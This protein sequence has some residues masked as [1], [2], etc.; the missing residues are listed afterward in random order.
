MPRNLA[1]AHPEHV[2]QVIT[3]ACHIQ[4]TLDDR[5]TLSFLF[6]RIRHRFDPEFQCTS[7]H[8]RGPLPVPSTSI[9]SRSD[10]VAHWSMCL[11][12][13]DDEHENVE[14]YSTHGG[15]GFN[16]F[17]YA[18]VAD[19][20]A[21]SEGEWRPFRAPTWLRSAYPRPADWR[22]HTDTAPRARPT[23]RPRRSGDAPRSPFASREGGQTSSVRRQ[24]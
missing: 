11:D 8:E 17:V 5:N 3:M 7:E 4:S 21:Q 18:V 15:Q 23:G 19:R 20:L 9:Y 1:R 16:P 22:D 2:R 6:D 13:T 10:G 14:V 12:L 24:K